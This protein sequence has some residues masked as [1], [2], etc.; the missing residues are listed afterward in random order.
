MAYHRRRKTIR[1]AAEAYCQGN[2]F[3]IT[4]GTYDRYPW[5][6]L[7]HQLSTTTVDILLGLARNRGSSLY[8]WC[9]MPDHIHLLLSN[10][11]ILDFVRLF[12]GKLIPEGRLL[13]PR[14]RLWQRSFYDHA[15]RMEEDLFEVAHYIWHNPVRAGIVDHAADYEFSGSLVWGNWRHFVRRG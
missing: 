1:L 13:N 12:K 14:R 7:H 15:L 11:S 2:P 10:D 6:Q 9:I 8:A 5:F 4:I 3:S